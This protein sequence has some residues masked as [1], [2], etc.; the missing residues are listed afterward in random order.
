[1]R[2]SSKIILLLTFVIVGLKTS[3]AQKQGIA[4]IDSM[5]L[6]LKTHQ[7]VDSNQV[8]IIYRIS[9]AY[10][11][12]YPDSALHYGEMGLN[13]A[14]KIKWPKGIAAFYGNYGALYI[15]NGDLKKAIFYSSE[16]LKINKSIGNLRGVA[17]N[18]INLGVVYLQQGDSPKALANYFSALKITQT[19]KDQDY[20]A[21]IY[22]NIAEIY[23][24]NQNYKLALKYALKGY[25]RYKLINIKGV[26]A[27]GFGIGNIYLEMND[28]KNAEI[29]ARKSQQIYT[30]LNNKTGQ[31]DVLGLLALIYH[32]D[33]SKKLEFLLK[34]R[35]LHDETNPLS[36]GSITN[37]GN[38]G[39]TY[40]DIYI[41]QLKDKIGPSP[42]I[43]NDYDNI[44][45]KAEF[46]LTKAVNASKEVGDLGNL[47]YISDGLAQ[48]QE[49]N[50][51]YKDALENYKLSYQITDSLYSQESKNQIASLEAQFAFQKKED[52]FKQEQELAKVKT[53]QIYLYAGIVVIL[54]S[55]ILI[56][57]LNRSHIS[58]L[59]LK[60][61]LLKKE[62][63][64][65][66]KELLHQSKLFESELKAIRSQMNPHFIFNVLNSIEAYI[67]DN[68]KKTASRLVQKFASLSRL[69]LENSTKSLVTGDKEW[70][71]LMLYTELEAMR[72]N[73]SFTFNFIVDEKLKLNKILLPPMLIQPLIENAI[74]HGLIV[75]NKPDAHLEVKLEL[76]GNGI[77]I[78]VT[79]NGV[80]IENKPKE[81]KTS[82]FKE[83]SIGLESIRERIEVISRQENGNKASFVI[84]AGLNSL[85]TI[86]TVCLPMLLPKMTEID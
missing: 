56:Y 27:A 19:I 73:H 49:K 11:N 74:L 40:A 30:D 57:L 39:G 81:K 69:I 50:G 29:Y 55:S 6:L 53:R 76:T 60:N 8:R 51:R 66:T 15:D 1:M 14:K 67:M 77:C 62:G 10:L 21:L 12:S 64:E 17:G 79:D 28:L 26:A 61:E 58:Q 71:A 86:A 59:R 16:A 37:L 78:T 13:M 3:L 24:G 4:A 41:N 7:K 52:Q 63:E 70:K 72:Y 38:I 5:K 33:K 23:R 44:A 32:D 36:S 54:I 47:S 83:K 34:A 46:Y 2:L 18:T 42:L 65:K 75:E 80:G 35:K 84:H 20:T 43:P 31:A 85:G 68:D 82:A 45:Q 25:E 48:L 9:D 22:G